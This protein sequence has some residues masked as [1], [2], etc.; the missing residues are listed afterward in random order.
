MCSHL[1]YHS[2]SPILSC[3]VL[4]CS[5]LFYII[6]H[7][8]FCSFL[9][10]FSF[11]FLFSVFCSVLFCSVLYYSVPRYSHICHRWHR[12]GASW[13]WDFY[14][15]LS[16]SYRV[17]KDTCYSGVCWCQIYSWYQE[18]LRSTWNARYAQKQISIWGGKFLD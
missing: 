5:V 12:W 16:R 10:Y 3:P 2:L 6:L 9:Y 7:V 13:S 11:C 14:G 17:R 1:S 18:N 8:V 4:F 15:Y